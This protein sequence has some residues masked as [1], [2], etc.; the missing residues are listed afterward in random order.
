MSVKH[1]FK[2]SNGDL[3]EETVSGFRGTI[4]GSA[5]YLTGCNQYCVVARSKDEFTE[6][7]ASWYDE[8]R[9]KIVE[10]GKVK[11]EQVKASKNGA[12]ISPSKTK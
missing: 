4:T 1:K 9:L 3:V 8:G 6:S 7:V 12:D 11:E 5:Y 10:K 2:Y